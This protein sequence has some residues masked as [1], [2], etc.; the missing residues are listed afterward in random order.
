MA[1]RPSYKRLRH[2]LVERDMTPVDLRRATG[3]ARNTMTSINADRSVSL[4]TLA[5]ICDY[6]GCRIEDV[7]EFVP[8]TE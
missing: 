2:I 5:V 8:A 4:E 6:L 7:V 3:L 1:L